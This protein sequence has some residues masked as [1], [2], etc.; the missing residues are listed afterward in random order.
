MC[1][2]SFVATRNEFVIT[3]NR[4]EH[5]LRSAIFPE[6][7]N[8][9]NHILFYPKDP[10]AGGTWYAVNQNG[11][12]LVLLNGAEE[13]HKH[14]PPYSRSRG[15]IVLEI[16]ASESPII[17]WGNID[18]QGVEPFTL[19]LFEN[20]KLYQLRWNE[21]EKSEIALEVSKAHI[22][23]SSTLYPQEIRKKR[24]DWFYTFLANKDSITAIDLLHFHENTEVENQENGLVINRDN[25]LKTLSITQSIVQKNNIKLIYK[26]LLQNEIFEK[27]IDIK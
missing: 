2:V 4:D 12:V 27:T 9:D 8:I 6:Q 3:S 21:T 18:L 20:Q 5:V 26:D 17:S 22:W 25:K 23:S 19:V 14:N 24:S 16:L 13:K 15:L 11:N 7:Y 10:L 1:T